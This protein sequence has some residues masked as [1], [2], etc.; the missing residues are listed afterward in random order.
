MTRSSLSTMRRLA[1]FEANDGRCHLCGGNIV[2]GE[3][4]E[5]EHVRPLSMGGEDGGDNLRPA[6]VACHAAKTADEAP[7]RAK[8]KRIKAKH[9]GIRKPSKFPASRDGKWK[10]KVGGGV[11]RRNEQ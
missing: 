11:V 7:I 1:V 3:K 6:H 4:W 2:A 9:L 8:A 10:Q 5:V